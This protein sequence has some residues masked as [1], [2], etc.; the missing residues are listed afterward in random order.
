MTSTS[1]ESCAPSVSSASSVLKDT[2]LYLPDTGLS[3]FQESYEKLYKLLK[4]MYQNDIIPELK[5]LLQWKLKPDLNNNVTM[6]HKETGEEI[7]A[8]FLLF[9]DYDKTTEIFSW[10][11][12][13]LKNLIRE[14]IESIHNI[15]EYLD[16][17]SCL[18]DEIFPKDTNKVPIKNG[19][20]VII[21]TLIRFL[22]ENSF[23]LIEI[24]TDNED[25]TK[26]SYALVNYDFGSSNDLD[27]I[28]FMTGLSVFKLSVNLKLHSQEKEQQKLD[29]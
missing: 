5:T 1:S 24:I 16:N 28:K 9:G 21:P 4:G 25:D 22:H 7:N 14:Y 15:T 19:D 13:D 27:I 18:I 23:R 26:I 11:S 17:A 29:E 20:H 12:T 10:K 6:K 3:L 8:L 2:S